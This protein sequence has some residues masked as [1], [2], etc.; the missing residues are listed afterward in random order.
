MPCYPDQSP[1]CR[2]HYGMNS[3]RAIDTTMSTVFTFKEYYE[4]WHEYHSRPGNKIIII[5]FHLRANLEISMLFSLEIHP[6]APPPQLCRVDKLPHQEQSSS[7]RR[8]PISGP[9][10]HITLSTTIVYCNIK[11]TALKWKWKVEDSRRWLV[12]IGLVTITSVQLRGYTWYHYMWVKIF[13]L[14]FQSPLESY[15]NFS[16]TFPKWNSS[17]S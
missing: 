6:K 11:I 3:H 4:L 16:R 1:D 15:Q 17:P 9:N 13:R 8:G 7:L 5:K 10:G 14:K 2:I 12:K